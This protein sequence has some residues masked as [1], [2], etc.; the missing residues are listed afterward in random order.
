M[1]QFNLRKLLQKNIILVSLFV[2][3]MFITY[4][5]VNNTSDTFGMG[6]VRYLTNHPK[7]CLKY[8]MHTRYPGYLA[9]QPDYKKKN[10]IILKKWQ[11]NEEKHPLSKFIPKR[12]LPWC[13]QKC[14][15]NH[16]C[17]SFATRN[18]TEYDEF[19]KLK[20]SIDFIFFIFLESFP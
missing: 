2:L 8:S 3:L 17:S 10:S 18:E 13:R 9:G 15:L 20:E 1:S 5:M 6:G 11:Y 16:M 4:K 19:H 12:I 14:T 7:M